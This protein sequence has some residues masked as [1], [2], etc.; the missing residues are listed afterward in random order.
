MHR[1]PPKSEK[2]SAFAEDAKVTATK[3]QL[4]VT[5]SLF[6]ATTASVFLWPHVGTAVLILVQMS[7]LV[8]VGW[9]LLTVIVSHRPAPAAPP[10]PPIWP[11]Y[12]IVVALHDEVAILPHLVERLSRLDYPEAL[13]DG[14][15]A[16][17][18]HDQTTIEAARALKRPDWLHVLIVPPGVPTTKPRALNHALAVAKGEFLTVYDAEDDPDPLQL[19]EAAARFATEEEDVVC[20]QAP[21]RIR[22]LYKGYEDSPFLDRH[23]AA[24]YAALFEITLPAMARMG[25]PFPL[26]GTSNHFRV[27]A[28]RA[29]GGWDAWNVTEDADLGFRIWRRG[30]RLGVLT[31]PTYE[32]PPGRLFHWLPQRTRWLKGYM[33]TLSVHCRSAAGMGWR[34]WSAMALTLGA[35]VASASVHALSVAWIGVPLLTALL[36][37]QAPQT[38]WLGL[39]VL[40]TGAAAAALTTLIGARRA[41]TPFN[42]WDMLTAPAYWSLL[43]LAFAH[44][45]VRL[46]AEPHRWDKT[47]HKPD[48]A[49]QDFPPISEPLVAESGRAAA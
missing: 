5:S 46:I 22:R 49:P 8:I 23:F 17:E 32:T 14:Y 2:T 28:L 38:P 9:R 36:A 35:A 44:A 34:G 30:W 13:L 6:G 7:F 27:S 3:T 45:F 16:L 41:N 26:G 39:S 42:A 12:S 10:P 11:H 43:S 33:Q 4:V 20:L 40:L 31:R 21:L 29:L 47:A 24:E 18:A 37:R 19:Q 1:R 48:V 25:M 15:L